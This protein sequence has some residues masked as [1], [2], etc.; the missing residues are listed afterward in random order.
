MHL[1]LIAMNMLVNVNILGTRKSAHHWVTFSKASVRLE[2]GDL[3]LHLHEIFTHARLNIL[4]SSLEI[5]LEDLR[6]NYPRRSFV[7]V[8]YLKIDTLTENIQMLR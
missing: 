3:N 4:Y 5:I 2:P 6:N 1:I 7:T 8:K